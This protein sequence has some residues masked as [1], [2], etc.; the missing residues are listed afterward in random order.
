TDDVRRS[1]FEP[2]WRIEIGR[3]LE[4]HSIDH[5]SAA[6]PGRKRSQQLG[7]APQATDAGGAVQLV[8]GEGVKV[9]ADLP[10]VHIDARHSL[11]AVEQEQS[12][13]AVRDLGRSPCIE[14]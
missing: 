12:A 5:R 11:A 4:R 13:L 8:R 2:G 3:L 14:N 6:L 1:R 9:R 7:A 10:N